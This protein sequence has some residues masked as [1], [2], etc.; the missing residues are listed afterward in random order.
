MKEAHC[1]KSKRDIYHSMMQRNKELEG[2]DRAWKRLC[3][4]GFATLVR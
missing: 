1:E 3:H 4:G 2:H